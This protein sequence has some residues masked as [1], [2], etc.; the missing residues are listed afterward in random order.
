[1]PADH[2]AHSV[3]V[4]ARAAQLHILLWVSTKG[5]AVLTTTVVNEAPAALQADLD[6]LVVFRRVG[7]WSRRTLDQPEYAIEQ[8]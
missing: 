4:Q 2:R 7:V 6:P 8:R 1:M 3:Q 5:A